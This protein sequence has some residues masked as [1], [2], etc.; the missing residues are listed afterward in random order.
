M[1]LVPL[2]TSTD[3]GL[4]ACYDADRHLLRVQKTEVRMD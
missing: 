2:R 3:W 4:D 1:V